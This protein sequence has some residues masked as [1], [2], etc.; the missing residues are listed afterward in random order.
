[1][2]KNILI[3]LGGGFL[4]AVLVAVLV[5]STLKGKSKSDDSAPKSQILVA[6]KDLA[7]GK[8]LIAGD[9][10]WQEWPQSSMFA[11]AIVREGEKPASEAA[12]GRVI[13]SISAGQP[14]H[15][16]LLVGEAKGNFLAAKLKEGMRAVG[17]SVKAQNIAGGFVGP[18]DFVD[19]IVT[20]KVSVQDKDNAAVQAMVS[21]QASETILEN[22]RV[23][24]ADQQAIRDEDKAKIVRTVTLEVDGVGAEKLA[25]AIEMGDVTL[26]LRGIG[27]NTLKQNDEITTDVKMSKVLR[28]LAKAQQGGAGGPSGAVRI[29]SGQNVTNMPVRQPVVEE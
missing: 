7:I 6:A 19:V 22:V 12:K 16:G 24:A 25:L 1:M 21:K 17:I 11:G 13:Q 18:G 2:N 3:V 8:E 14:I 15:P 9:V 23:L 10:K 5:Q 4:I 26:S 29:Y 27:D 28:N 20:Y